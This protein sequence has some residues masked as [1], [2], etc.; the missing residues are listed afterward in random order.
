MFFI[1]LGRHDLM[2]G[3]STLAW[4][5]CISALSIVFLWPHL[6][7]VESAAWMMH[8]E[9]C[10]TRHRLNDE[11]LRSSLCDKGTN[12][13]AQRD[14]VCFC[15]FKSKIEFTL[16]LGKLCQSTRRKRMGC[17]SMC[18]NVAYNVAQRG[19]IH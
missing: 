9:R 16:R 11:L 19:R 1:K 12:E 17:R 5:V 6:K 7:E 2:W 4:I 8:Y 14:K 3:S 18:T 13:L 10:F 15:F